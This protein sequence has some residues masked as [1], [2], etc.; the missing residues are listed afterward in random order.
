MPIKEVAETCTCPSIGP[1]LMDAKSHQSGCPVLEHFK[2][3]G[4]LKK[5]V[6][7]RVTRS[8]EGLTG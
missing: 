5:D 3:D 8:A 1:N 4:T 2:V 7:L 6:V